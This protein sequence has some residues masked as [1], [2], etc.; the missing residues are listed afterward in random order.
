MSAD[1]GNNPHNDAAQ[2]LP[3][4]FKDQP[5]LKENWNRP[6]SQIV[7]VDLRKDAPE[8]ADPAVQE[9]HRIYCYLLMKL[10]HRFWNGNKRG[11]LGTYPLRA[12]QKDVAPPPDKPQRYRGEMIKNTG[13]LRVNWDR[14]LGHN[15]ACLAVDGNGEIMDFDFNHN[16]LFRS[17]AEHAEARMVRRHFSLTNISDNWQTRLR[18]KGKPLPHRST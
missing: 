4:G 18:P 3:P 16:D 8:L 2:P 10:V 5:P 13:G 15:I 11:P 12:E 14:Y 7:E 9:R 1:D 17:S 6:L